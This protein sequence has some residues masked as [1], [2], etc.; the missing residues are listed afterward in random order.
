[1]VVV[2]VSPRCVDATGSDGAATNVPSR[3]DLGVDNNNTVQTLYNTA[4]LYTAVM[5][6]IVCRAPQG[7]KGGCS[8]STFVQATGFKTTITTLSKQHP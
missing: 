1:M 2:I 7:Q 6:T 8:L 4:N 5:G 3:Q